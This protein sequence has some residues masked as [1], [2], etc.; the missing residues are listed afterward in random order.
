LFF[1]AK[2]FTSEAVFV[3]WHGF[4]LFTQWLLRKC[5]LRVYHIA[6]QTDN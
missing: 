1:A 3:V 6:K 2:G 4:S 5:F